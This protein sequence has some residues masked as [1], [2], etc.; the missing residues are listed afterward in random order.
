VLMDRLR[1]AA[2]SGQLDEGQLQLVNA[3]LA[4]GPAR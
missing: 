3:A 1:L 2:L 4:S